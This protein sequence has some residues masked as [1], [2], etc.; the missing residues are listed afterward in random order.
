MAD[1]E[2]ESPG[3]PWDPSPSD[4]TCDWTIFVEEGER[5]FLK[6]DTFEV[7]G[8]GDL[9]EVYDVYSD[10]ARKLVAS[11]SG[12]KGKFVHFLGVKL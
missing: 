5:V 6:F 8:P 9:V 2:L 7:D 12:N 10:M 11:F 1:P 3:Y 4:E